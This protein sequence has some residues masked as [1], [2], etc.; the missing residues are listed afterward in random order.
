MYQERYLKSTINEFL[1]KR[2]VFLGGPRQVG[3]TTLC[4]SFLTK[5]SAKNPAY[6]NW[7]DIQSRA[8]LRQGQL[9]ESSLV[10]I[11]EIH[12]YLQVRSLLQIG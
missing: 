6:L 3:K 8:I 2:M 10:V 7:D 4:L 5:P 1:S 9:P 12:K 11:D